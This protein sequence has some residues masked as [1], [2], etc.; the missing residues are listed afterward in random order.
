MSPEISVASKNEVHSAT[1]GLRL[2]RGLPR[3]HIW[4]QEGLEVP[5]GFSLPRLEVTRVVFARVS[6]AG[7]GRGPRLAPGRAR[8]RRYVHLHPPCR[9]AGPELSAPG[10]G[11]VC[12][13]HP[14][15]HCPHTL[16]FCARRTGAKRCLTVT[17][18]LS[19]VQ[20]SSFYGY[21]GM[22]PK[23]YTQG[24]MTGESE[25]LQMPG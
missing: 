5:E 24:V 19:Q 11:D 20:Q 16:E 22:L 3:H 1:Q 14:P 6:L 25:Y 4:V 12:S 21:T 18:S 8:G 7:T 13:P 17:L 10:G 2:T 9:A 15:Q 23:R